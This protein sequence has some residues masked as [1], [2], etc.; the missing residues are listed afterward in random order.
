MTKFKVRFE[1]TGDLSQ[2]CGSFYFFF[3]H[4]KFS[5][6][7]AHAAIVS[8]EALNNLKKEWKLWQKKK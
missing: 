2:D 8:C 1:H 5:D 3:D 7:T 6:I 4:P